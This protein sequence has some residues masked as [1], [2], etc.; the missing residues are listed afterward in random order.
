MGF[1]QGNGFSAVLGCQLDDGL[2]RW[3]ADFVLAA[4]DLVV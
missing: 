1:Q 2:P 4:L 3:I